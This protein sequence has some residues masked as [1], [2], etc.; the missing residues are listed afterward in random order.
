MSCDFGL[1]VS[2]LN[3]DEI[4]MPELPPPAEDGRIK[5]MNNNGYAT[6]YLEPLSE[7]FTDYAA[8]L[9]VPVLDGGAAYGLTSITALKKGAIVIAN[10]IDQKHLDYIAKIPDLTD[11]QRTRLYIK[12]GS[13]SN[14]DFPKNSLGAIHISRVMHFF[15]PEEVE[16]FFKKAQEWLVS[17]G[18]IYLITMS[19]YHYANPEGYAKVY[20]ENYKNGMEWPGERPEFKFKKDDGYYLQALDPRVIFRVAT[21][22]GFTIKKLELWGGPHDD[23]YT[24]GIFIKEYD[25]LSQ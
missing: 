20:E 3:L 23:D 12:F 25:S 1:R 10:E 18:R 14:I 21:K 19:Q 17:N 13:L 5:T 7:E 22:Y 24:C 11:E 9:K 8:K 16:A 6:P 2:E 15:H 4:V